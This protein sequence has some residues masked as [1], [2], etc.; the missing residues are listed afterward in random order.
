MIL[1]HRLPVPSIGHCPDCPQSFEPLPA[2]PSTAMPLAP[3]STDF[4][5]WADQVVELDRALAALAPVAMRVGIDPPD[6]AEWH[7]LLRFKLLPQLEGDPLLV[8]AMVGGTNIGKSSLFNHLAGE[9]ASGV[10]PLAAGTKHPVCLVPPGMSDPTALA[11]LFEEFDLA[12]WRSAD[13]PLGDSPEDML[14]WRVGQNV[15]PRLLLLDAPDVDSDVQVNWRRARAIRQ[16]ADVLVAVL[17]QQKYNDAAVK[18]FFREAVAADKPIVVV[19]N[20]CDLGDDRAYWPQWLATFSAETG[21]QP[22]LVYVVPHDREAVH[23]LRLPFY[24]V[25][26]EAARPPERPSSLREELARLHFDAIKIRTLR[27]ALAR[28]LDAEC[29]APAYLH[30]IRTAAGDFAAAIDALSTTEMARVAWPTLPPRLLVDEIRAWWDADRSPWSRNIHGFYRTLGRGV[31]WPVRAAMGRLRPEEAAVDPFRRREGEAIVTAVENMLSELDRLARVGNEILRPRLLELL[32]GDAR[33]R[34]LERVRE[35]H[36]ELPPVD[37]DYRQFLR[38][39][40]DTWREQN[41]MAVRWLR[42][43]DHAAALAR[44]A[45][46]TALVVAGWGIAGPLV[47]QPGH[48]LVDLPLEA[49]VTSTITGVGEAGVNVA[50]EGVSQAAGR[51]FRRLQA[52]YARQR[53]GWLADW[54]ERELMGGLLRELRRGAEVPQSGP[55]REVEAVLDALRTSAR[56]LSL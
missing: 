55:F 44:P 23:A 33:Q 17:T 35:A 54:L 42:R 16:S 46:T 30:R 14:Y 38:E 6:E 7:E 4:R 25:G 40:L 56:D 50:G 28:V 53:A 20:Q 48:L 13:D 10:S 19:F 29:G 11:G 41:P 39:E 5:T 12:P 37:D 51:L 8:V 21:A 36:A 34:L 26:P 43:F 32:R 27:G 47:G 18:Q 15:P 9:V 31:A 2:V 22:E 3:T 24:S 52:R 1:T 45:I 49:V